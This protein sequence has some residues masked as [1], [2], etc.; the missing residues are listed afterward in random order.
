MDTDREFETYVEKKLARKKRAYN[1]LCETGGI[2]RDWTC[3]D[4]GSTLSWDSQDAR[5]RHRRSA[6]HTQKAKG[7][8]PK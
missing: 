7:H 5:Q 1:V 8:I 6:K 4:C 2:R 3:E